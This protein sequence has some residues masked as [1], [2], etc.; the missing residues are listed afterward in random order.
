MRLFEP[1]AG[2][3]TAD[4][5]DIREYDLRSWRGAI[6]FVSQDT[7]IFN[8][9]IAENI[10]F[11]RPEATEDEVVEAA[12]L[13]NAHEFIMELADGYATL[14]GDRGLKLSGGQ[15]QRVVIAR[16]LVRTPQI[17]IFDEATS[18]LDSLSEAVVQDAIERVRKD[19]TVI[20]VAH[21]LSTIASADQIVVI[22]RG[23]IVECGTH[24]QL[25]AA[26]G[27]YYELYSGSGAE[28]AAEAAAAG[29]A[30]TS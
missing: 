25:L 16:A 30:P 24:A 19:R 17:V 21:R 10:R 27:H 11:G 13:A 2:R 4:G 22:D 9:T 28:E 1:Q 8:G 20:M 3:I 6:G 5:V 14:V 15:R 18:A 12:K 23:Q 7:F 29:S 26:G